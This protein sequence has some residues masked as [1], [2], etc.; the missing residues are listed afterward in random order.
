[1]KSTAGM[2]EL[3]DSNGQR[4]KFGNTR[5]TECW[6]YIG[7]SPPSEPDHPCATT[8][9]RPRDFL[10]AY[11]Q[12]QPLSIFLCRVSACSP[13]PS[14]LRIRMGHEELDAA[15][16]SQVSG[17]F[18]RWS[19]LRRWLGVM[20]WHQHTE[21]AVTHLPYATSIVRSREA[22]QEHGAECERRLQQKGGRPA[23]GKR[24]AS[25]Q[26]RATWT[27]KQRKGA[28]VK[29]VRWTTRPAAGWMSNHEMRRPRTIKSV[30]RRE[31]VLVLASRLKARAASD[32][33]RRRKEKEQLN[34][35]RRLFFVFFRTFRISLPALA[36]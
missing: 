2:S 22:L 19:P 18:Q 30:L 21:R 34:S 36:S 23:R 6:Q 14:C 31:A 13:L 1:M 35:S 33:V 5:A 17:P 20:P 27:G 32:E 9:M 7:A 3:K 10:C 26:I 15:T 28:R 12:R 29:V 4:H 24:C 16:H 11:L 25:L 8:H